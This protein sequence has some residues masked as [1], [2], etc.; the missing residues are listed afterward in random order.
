[1]LHQSLVQRPAIGGNRR[2]DPTANGISASATVSKRLCSPL[3]NGSWLW[4]SGNGRQDPSAN[5]LSVVGGVCH[6][7]GGCSPRTIENRTIQDHAHPP[8]ATG[9]FAPPAPVSKRLCRS[10]SPRQQP[11]GEVCKRGGGCCPANPAG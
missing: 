7:A 8:P 11:Q 6:L 9:L 2:Q 3:I 4:S 1:H 5:G 10:L